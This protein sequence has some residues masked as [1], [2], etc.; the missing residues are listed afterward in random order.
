MADE[1]M[2]ITIATVPEH[3]I[4]HE[5]NRGR[6]RKDDP[7]RRKY[8]LSEVKDMLAVIPA[9]DRDLW[10]HVG[11]I[12]GRTFQCSD[13]AWQVYIEWADKWEGA[14]DQNHDKHMRHFFYAK[15]Q[16]GADRELSIGTIVKLAMEH[17]WAPTTGRISLDA[18][19]YHVGHGYL[20]RPTMETWPAKDTDIAVSPM[21]D[22]GVMRKATEILQRRRLVTCVTSHPQLAEYTPDRNIVKGE[23]VADS[24]AAILNLYRHATIPLGEAALATPWVEHCQRLFTKPGDCD[25]FFNFMAHRV[26]RPWEKMRFALLIGGEQGTGK[27]TAI[28][29]CV[30]AIGAWNVENIT[31]RALQSSF[32]AYLVCALLR[33][34]EAADAHDQSRWMLNEQ[35]KNI[36]AGTPDH[37]TI[38]GKYQ[39]T[40]HVRLYCAVLVTTN[41]LLTSV[42]IPEDD[43]RYDVIECATRKEMGLGDA[44]KRREYFSSLW[45]WFDEQK[46]AQHV[47]AFL[48]QRDL[49]GF[50]AA[51]GQRKTAAHMEIVQHGMSGD[52]WLRDI[53]DEMGNPPVLI[54]NGILERAVGMGWLKKDAQ[55]KLGYGLRR[56]GYQVLSNPHYGDG[57]WKLNGVL[58]RVYKHR[59]HR[60]KPEPDWQEVLE[61][62][63]EGE[64]PLVYDKEKNTYVHSTS[65]F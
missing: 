46:G 56:M 45:K 64:S 16:E 51:L 25:Q 22:D 15:S 54:G 36:I 53:V 28:E 41:H 52:E 30:P 7:T 27:D 9:D 5:E 49:S 21:M 38:N 37:A 34:N 65:E 6:P 26:Q 10:L 61:I 35:L 3:L 50:S 11:I 14:R 8:G 23:L 24:G 57:R 40:Q 20:Y 13:D 1:W 29:M 43:R 18:L 32:N 17:G 12:L 62:P 59:D 42:H 19:Y 58:C 48:H 39:L 33:V 44:E 60:P 63:G 31:P 47:A 4:P 55:A 2:N